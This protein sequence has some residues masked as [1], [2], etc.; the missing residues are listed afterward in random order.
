MGEERPPAGNDRRVVL[1]A[2]DAFKGTATAPEIAAAVDAA[3]ADAGW[4]CD[5]CPL[6]DGGEGFATVMAEALA[7][8]GEWRESSVEGPLGDAVVARWWISQT[9]SGSQAVIESAAASGLSLAGGARQNDPVA[10]STRGTGALIVGAMRAGVRRILLGVGGSATTDG[11][12]GAFE[13]IVDAG[14][15]ADVEL[16][17]ACDVATGFL[18]AARI[19]GPQKGADAAQV[20]LLS[21]RLDA[22]AS[23][24]QARA[25]IDV[26]ALDG[27]GAAGGLA[28]G[29]AVL[30]ARL[31]PG[32]NVVADA[33]GLRRRMAAADLV[34]TGEGRLDPTSWSG[35]V[36][37]GVV[38]L[39]AEGVDGGPDV[40]VVAGSID[41]AWRRGLGPL[42]APAIIDLS[43]RFGV[44]T[45]QEEPSRCV[46]EAMDAE[47]R[48][49]AN[50]GS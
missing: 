27:A 38:A 18:D 33:T 16:V 15:L 1:A 19:F 34:V 49:R 46:T 5:R 26:T 48:I 7:D 47:L 39:A 35:K 13:V 32:F 41:T 12:I 40:V 21:S 44:Q 14:G 28:G 22:L 8:G 17:V 2:P 25:G 45:A 31:V 10:A 6:S 30:G 24:Y 29:L 37:G 11:G 50:C 36:V 23:E 20:S 42:P 4:A 3:A 9:A 43:A